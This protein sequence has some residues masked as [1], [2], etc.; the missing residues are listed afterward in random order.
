[1]CNGNSLFSKQEL[2]YL[3]LKTYNL[4][5]IWHGSLALNTFLMGKKRIKSI[6]T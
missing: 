6:K 5:S 2:S 4:N 3:P 1:M